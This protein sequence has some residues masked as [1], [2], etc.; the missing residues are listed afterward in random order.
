MTQLWVDTWR[1]KTSA[2]LVGNQAAIKT[3]KSWLQNWGA[4]KKAIL[5]SGPPGIG[6]TSSAILVCRELGFEPIEVNASDTRGKSDDLP[7]KGMGAKL[8]NAVKEMT[9]NRSISG[10]K[11]C[12]IMDEVDGM[13][14]GDRG[15][16]SDLVKIIKTTC[17]PIIAICNDKYSSKIKMIDAQELSFRRPMVS[18]ISKRMLDICRAEGLAADKDTMDAFIQSA[19]GD[20]R[21]ILGEL[22][23]IRLRSSV[24]P[25]GAITTKDL[26]IKPFDASRRLLTEEIEIQEQIDLIF[27]DADL[28]PLLVQENYLN[29][30]P[31]ISKGNSATRLRVIVKAAEGI[32]MGDVANRAIHQ[33]QQWHLMPLAMTLSTAYPSTYMRGSRETFV[34]GELNF[35]RFPAWLGRTSSAGKQRRLMGELHA[36][37]VS[38]RK[39]TCDRTSL[40][41]FY[42]STLRDALIRPLLKGKGGIEPAVCLMREYG[43]IREDI[44]FI[45]DVTNFKSSTDPWKSVETRIKSAFTRAS[46]KS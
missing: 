29:H 35:P 13:S 4:G 31:K 34:S 38:S 30:C 20:I 5:I 11:S 37:M 15:G 2:D 25:Q 14:A 3:L 8:A 26:A 1:P 6:K 43:I 40:R 23:M 39:I 22:Q 12:L 28:V 36:R 32:S 33:Y 41:L 9:T 18:Q 17:I 44:D 27:Q 10:R 7:F 46:K 45:A 21:L 16:V 42:M 19:H 24:L